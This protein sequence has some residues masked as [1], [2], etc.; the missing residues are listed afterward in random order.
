MKLF[1]WATLSNCISNPAGF[2]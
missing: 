2:G 1:S